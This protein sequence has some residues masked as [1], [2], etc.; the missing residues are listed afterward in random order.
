MILVDS[1][2]YIDWLRERTNFHVRLEPWLR[3]GRLVGCGVVRAEVLRGVVDRRQRDR[4]AEFFGLFPEVPTDRDLW[5]QVA[6]AAWDLDRRGRVLPLSDIVI[7]SCAVRA[8]AALVSSDPH[9]RDFPG[10]T[11]FPNLEAAPLD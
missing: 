11:L 4:T 5:G 3:S 2:L 10:L 9:F 1:T 7:G 8:G 6:G